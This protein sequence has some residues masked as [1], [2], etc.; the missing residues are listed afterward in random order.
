MKKSAKPSSVPKT[1]AFSIRLTPRARAAL[2]KAG[3]AEER[4]AAWIAQRAVLAWLK[5]NGFL[6]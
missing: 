3:E 1:T 2:I 6:K 4:A 5:E